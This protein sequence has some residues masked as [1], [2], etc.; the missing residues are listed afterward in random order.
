MSNVGTSC[1]PNE[2]PLRY[3]AAVSVGVPPAPC[4]LAPVATV[5][6]LD[7]TCNILVPPET[8]E[9]PTCSLIVFPVYPLQSVRVVAS[10]SELVP[11]SVINF[12]ESSTEIHI[13]MSL[14]A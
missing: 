3:Q 8:N 4:Q 14:I 11:S 7:V 13:K 2:V 1:V 10:K 12:T 6:V 9:C 5:A